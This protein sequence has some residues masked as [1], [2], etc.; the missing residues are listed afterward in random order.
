MNLAR[1]YVPTMAS[2]CASAS[3]ERRTGTRVRLSGGLP[4]GFDL[5]ADSASIKK[6]APFSLASINGPVYINGTL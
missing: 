1:P 6:T 3:G 5:A 4:I 2:I